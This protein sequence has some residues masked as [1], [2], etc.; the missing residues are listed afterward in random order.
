MTPPRR[1]GTRPERD[2][3]QLPAPGAADIRIIAADPETAAAV[4][5][6]LTERFPALS[7]SAPFPAGPAGAATGARLYATIAVQGENRPG[8]S[9]EH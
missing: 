1:G 2:R 7:E 8:R 4:L 5:A 9:G 6:H 3:R